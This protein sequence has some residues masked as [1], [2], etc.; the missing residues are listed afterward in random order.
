MMDAVRAIDIM[1]G[2]GE[3]DART[4][5]LN[6]MRGPVVANDIRN[7][8]R[9]SLT[10]ADPVKGVEAANGVGSFESLMGGW[11]S[12]TSGN[13]AFSTDIKEEGSA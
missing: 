5:E 13:K 2:T 7:D 11:M 3:V 6:A 4:A 8:P 1:E 10:K 9:F 12:T